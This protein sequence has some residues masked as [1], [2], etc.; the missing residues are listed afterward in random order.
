MQIP[1]IFCYK[2]RWGFYTFYMSFSCISSEW[3]RSCSIF[4]VLII[5]DWLNMDFN[6]CKKLG[7][8]IQT[9]VCKHGSWKKSLSKNDSYFSSSFK[10]CCLIGD[11]KGYT[12]FDGCQLRVVGGGNS[13]VVLVFNNEPN[14]TILLQHVALNAFLRTRN[15]NCLFLFLD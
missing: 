14:N 12:M 3:T 7:L 6:V 4:Q 1:S 2:A 8:V 10:Y 9:K 11:K 13:C 5:Y 15:I